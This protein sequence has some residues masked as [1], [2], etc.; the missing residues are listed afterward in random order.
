[1]RDDEIR[2]RLREVNPWWRASSGGDPLGWVASDRVLRDRD[3]YDLGYRSSVLDDIANGPVDD[4]LV[5]LRGPRRVGKSVALKDTVVTL[6]GRDDVDPRQVIYLPADGMQARHL[7][8]TFVLGREL[9]RSVDHARPRPRMWLLDEVTG[10]DDWTAVLKYQR[11]N[12]PVGDDTVVCTGSSWSDTGDVERDLLAGRA[13]ATAQRRTRLLFPMRFRDV[14]AA[15][16]PELGRPA[17][18]APWQLQG[19]MAKKLA[20]ELELSTDDL[21]LAWQS[22]LTS[23]GFPRAVAEHTRD[24]MVSQSFL[25]DLAAW[26][27]RDVDHDAS[28][29][30]ISKLL[31]EIQ[32]RSTSPLNRRSTAEHLGYPNAQTF[33]VRL[34]RLTRSFAG[35][36]CHQITDT[37][38]RIS[39]SQ[40]KFYLTDPVLG[41]LGHRLRAGLPEPSMTAL[42]EST[43][44]TAMALAIDDAQPGRWTSAD[45][46]GYVRTGSGNE[47][48]L[49][50]VPVPT[51]GV[52]QQTTPVEA[53]WVSHGWRTEARV[54]EAK[55]GRG[56]VAT[57]DITDFENPSWAI[58]VPVLALML[59]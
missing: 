12:T 22:Y 19:P 25:E 13:G 10:I 45:T 16:R 44:A 4:K 52:E 51:R 55:Y 3:R 46:I 42:T 11:D 56:I 47:V 14:L 6:C 31:A 33:D 28:P 36:W 37:G 9:T 27:H 40:S 15:T 58:P 17:P 18:I 53:K 50:P 43:L 26:L 21:D 32:H 39:G 2:A 30:S 23:G 38:A 8:R 59:T 1:M 49:G 54:I 20:T 34:N 24:G 7:R 41:W 57:K 5:V 29:D 48:D 35:L